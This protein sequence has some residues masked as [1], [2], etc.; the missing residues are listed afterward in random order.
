MGN[1]DK[2]DDISHYRVDRIDNVT[3]INVPAR[4]FE[5]VSDYRGKFDVSDY[6]GRTF[7]MFSGKIENIVLICNMSILELIIDK[8][9][10]NADY[11][12]LN[13]E[14][15]RIKTNGYYSEGLVDWLMMIADKCRVEEP[16]SLRRALE[17]RASKIIE[18][19]STM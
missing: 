1:Y 7:R 3:V 11:T 10:E 17:Q 16:V 14:E 12:K 13:D 4:S 19:Q 5:E 2:Y 18:L 15:F 8:F 9:G 6:A